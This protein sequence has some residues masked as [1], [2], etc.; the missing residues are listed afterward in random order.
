MSNHL[1]GSREVLKWVQGL[2]LSYSI[3]NSKRDLANGFLIAEILSR[4]YSD[5]VQMHAYDT[6]TG[7]LQRKTTGIFLN[8]FRETW[9]PVPRDYAADVAALRND[10]GAL[11]L[12]NYS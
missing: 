3:K 11:V 2:N 5:T 1:I 4:Y 10:A 6:G 8:E 12:S 7:P 9:D